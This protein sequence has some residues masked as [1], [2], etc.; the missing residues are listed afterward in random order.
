MI[1][2]VEGAVKGSGSVRFE[3]HH[4]PRSIAEVEED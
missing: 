2:G 3:S 4:P 1:N